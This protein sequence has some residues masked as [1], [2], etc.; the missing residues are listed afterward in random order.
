MQQES[1]GGRDDERRRRSLETDLTT[2]KQPRPSRRPRA[3][4]HQAGS[5]PRRCAGRS[6]RRNAATPAL[7][8]PCPAEGHGSGPGT[9]Q[10]TPSPTN[11]ASAWGVARPGITKEHVGL[12]TVTRYPELE[13]AARQ[14]GILDLYHIYI[15]SRADI[16]ITPGRPA[17]WGWFRKRDLENF[18]AWSG[19]YKR[20]RAKDRVREAIRQ[21]FFVPKMA[22]DGHIYLRRVSLA[23]VAQLLGVPGVCGRGQNRLLWELLES[24]QV[25]SASAHV[26]VNAECGRRYSRRRTARSTKAKKLGVTGR[27]TRRWEKRLDREARENGFPKPSRSRHNYVLAT[28]PDGCQLGADDRNQAIELAIYRNFDERRYSKYRAVSRDDLYVR[29]GIK[30]YL[31]WA[32]LVVQQVGNSLW[33][34][35]LCGSSWGQRRLNEA[36]E[37]SFATRA[38]RPGSARGPASKDSLPHAKRWCRYIGAVKG[39]FHGRASPTNSRPYYLGRLS[40]PIAAHL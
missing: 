12:L 39:C 37:G 16:E 31:R 23:K 30:A 18:L 9:P 27:T 32:Y 38:S 4:R 35:V 13:V 2:E 28:W 29:R 14:K 20:A 6:R 25:S 19:R 22:N 33:T 8:L 11:G 17:C 5:P 36:L 40:A 15:I 10:R 34:D 1:V 24:T 3:P 7:P 26:V 21:G